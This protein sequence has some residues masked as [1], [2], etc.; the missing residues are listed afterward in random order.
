MPS[1]H[2][3]AALRHRVI[4]RAQERCEYCLLHQDDV[5]FSHHLDH[6]LPRKH[7]GDSVSENLALACL[8]C[9]RYKGS[10]LT[11]IDPANGAISLLF[12]P[13]SHMWEVHFTLEGTHIAGLPAVGRATVSL[14]RFNAPRRVTQRQLLMSIGRYPPA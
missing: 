1:R 13:R 6:I 11:A 10:D 5:P 3:P 7:G 12:N 4:Q 9:N 8:E 2:I 14:L